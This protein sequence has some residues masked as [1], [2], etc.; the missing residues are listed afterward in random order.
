MAG[1]IKIS[2]EIDIYEKG[3]VLGDKGEASLAMSEEEKRKAMSEKLKAQAV[4]LQQT[5]QFIFYLQ[6]LIDDHSL[7]F[8]QIQDYY[9]KDEVVTFKKPKVIFKCHFN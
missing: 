5:S 9:T 3:F 2:L 1:L 8:K 4:S 7:D 6:E